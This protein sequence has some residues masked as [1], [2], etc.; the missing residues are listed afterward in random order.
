M[1]IES[2]AIGL[3]Y[4]FL[5]YEWLGLVAGG[6]IAPGYVA[7]SFDDPIALGVCLLCSL[8]T[9][10]IVKYLSRFTILFG[11]RRFIVC[12]LLAF[13]LEWIFAEL[14]MDHNFS[15]GRMDV[16]GYV[17]PGLL[18]NE[19]LRQG[20]GVTLLLLLVLSSLTW[21]TLKIMTCI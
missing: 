13:F 8:L 10:V 2:I 19:M 21:I 15:Q 4:G 14:I 7:M 3:V 5:F 18:S 20:V 16:I 11:R 12:V 6:L 9:M 1:L 17:I